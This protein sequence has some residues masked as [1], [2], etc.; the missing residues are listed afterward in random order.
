MRDSMRGSMPSP[1]A[2]D[3]VRQF[4]TAMTAPPALPPRSHEFIIMAWF[5]DVSRES[6]RA[7]PWCCPC[8]KVVPFPSYEPGRIGGAPLIA[9]SRPVSSWASLSTC[10]T[11]LTHI[12]PAR[13]FPW[14]TNTYPS[15]YREKKTR[16]SRD[17][18]RIFQCRQDR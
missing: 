3:R 5:S 8:M 14:T 18:P 6:R 2:R 1:S 10:P 11:H 17:H 16:K 9:L 7:H 15:T 12:Q 13:A 4:A